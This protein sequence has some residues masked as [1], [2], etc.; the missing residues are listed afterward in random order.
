MNEARHFCRNP[1]C[2]MK[3]PAPVENLHKA[4]CTRGCHSSFYLRRCLVC[5][6]RMI[7][8]R[9]DQRFKSG[10]GKCEA[11]YRRFPHVYDFRGPSP[12][13]SDVSLANAHSTGLQ[14]SP[15]RH[16]S[17]RHWSWHHDGLVENELRDTAGTLLARIESN[18]GRHRITYPRTRPI[19]SCP[20]LE[21]AKHHAESFALMAMPKRIPH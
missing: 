20:D 10:H 8:K 12:T 5:E 1:R 6:D 7:R 19:R 2:R 9:S 21:E 17:L 14:T 18:A 11:E 16:R 13:I 15:P 3:L 4:F